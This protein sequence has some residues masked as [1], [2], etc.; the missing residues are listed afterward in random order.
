MRR[1][2]THY[3]LARRWARKDTQVRVPF[4]PPLIGRQAII[5]GVDHNA[6]HCSL[7]L[8]GSLVEL[9]V[10][11]YIQAYGPSHLPQIGHTCWVHLNGKDLVVMGQHISP[12]NVVTL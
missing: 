5:T 2:E 3:E 11:S 6:H 9:P 1:H 4:C 8:P 12:F 10:A 7:Q